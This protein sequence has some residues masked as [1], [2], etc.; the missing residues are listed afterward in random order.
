MLFNSTHFLIFFPIVAIGFFCLPHRW[1]TIWLLAASAYFY[2]A[3]VPAYVLILFGMILVDYF[4]GWQIGKSQGRRRGFWLWFSVFSTCL[5]LFIFKYFDFINGNL[6]ALAEFI[7]WNYPIGILGLLL[8]IGLSFHTFQSLGYVID[9]YRGV[10]LPEKNFLVYA[11]YV[12][13]F[14]QLVAGPI[15]RSTRL[16]PQLHL[17]VFFDSNR[18]SSGLRLMLWGFFKKIMIADNAALIVGTIYAQPENYGGLALALGT[19]FFALQI[20]ADFSGYSD[21][22]IGSARVLGYDLMLNFNHP[23]FSKTVAEFW[24]RWHI[25]LMNWFRDYV[26]IPLGGSRVPTGRWLANV[27]VVFLLSGLWHGANWTFVIWGL[28]NAVYL[29]IGKFTASITKYLPALI[30]VVITFILINITWIFFRAETVSQALEIL[31][32]IGVSLVSGTFW[33][34]LINLPVIAETWGL[35]K[36]TFIALAIAT[37]ILIAADWASEFKWSEKWWPKL[38]RPF[39]WAAYYTLIIFIILF[40]YFG[41]KAFIYFQF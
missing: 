28:L 17:P 22:A 35:S 14:P 2:M 33:L 8:P 41:A 16:L 6:A 4:A 11:L 34:D 27:F 40:G 20:Y 39:R 36:N 32:T 9:V 10:R 7:H 19:A 12:M 15:E 24:R 5:I 13:F 29:V 31:K 1:R 38:S 37:L 3:F 23:Y 25:S 18:V 21:I 30:K 26:Y